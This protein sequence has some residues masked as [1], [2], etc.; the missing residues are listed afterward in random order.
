KSDGRGNV[1]AK[2][3]INDFSFVQKRRTETDFEYRLVSQAMSKVFSLI[4]STVARLFEKNEA[5]EKFVCIKGSVHQTYTLVGQFL[6][7]LELGTCSTIGG[8]NAKIFVRV[9][10]PF[11]LKSIMNNDYENGLTAD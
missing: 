3:M 6:D 11:R 9:N 10:D 1:P 4:R 5:V 7:S 8:E 2:E